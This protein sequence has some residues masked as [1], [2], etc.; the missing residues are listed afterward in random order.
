V[1]RSIAQLPPH[2]KRINRHKDRGIS[3]RN[4]LAPKLR[5]LIRHRNIDAP[6]HE[7]PETLLDWKTYWAV[8]RFSG[9]RMVIESALAKSSG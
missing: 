3:W 4:W 5:E 7:I 8:K 1:T 2:M 9:T 6:A